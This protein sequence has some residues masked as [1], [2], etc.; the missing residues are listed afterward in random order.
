MNIGGTLRA[1]SLKYPDK[2]ALID[3]A[4]DI[5][6]T[7]QQL[8]KRVNQLAHALLDSGV[9]AGDRV[10]VLLKNGYQYV[11]IAYAVAKIGAILVPLNFRLN[12]NEI[13][14]ILKDCDPKALFL[15]AEFRN[16]I[17]SSLEDSTPIITIIV[18]EEKT[19]FDFRYEQFLSVSDAKEPEL[20]VDEEDIY[21]ILYT[22]GTTGIPKGVIHTHRNLIETS[23]RYIIEAKIVHDDHTLIVSP[24]FHLSGLVAL[25]PSIIKGAKMTMM[26]EYKPELFLQIIN[27]YQIT[28]SS[29][30]PTMINKSLEVE[31]LNRFD[32]THLRL[33]LYGGSTISAQTLKRSD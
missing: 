29:P 23:T 4:Q 7:Y 15:G 27:D 33:F 12:E 28:F 21:G 10:A 30:V 16:V 9:H 3:P 1:T 18:D 22:S 14:F 31:N 32:F 25:F 17:K 6:M 13:K 26:K 20:D 5:A 11:E 8:N 19:E 24:L 2:K